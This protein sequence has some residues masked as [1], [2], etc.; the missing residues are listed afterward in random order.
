MKLRLLVIPGLLLVAIALLLLAPQ[1]ANT[2]NSAYPN[3]VK[4][5]VLAHALDVE[6][7][8]VKPA[9]WER[10]ISSGAMYAL[11]QATGEI[12]R[13]ASAVKNASAPKLPSAL[14][15]QGCQNV[16]SSLNA[17]DNIRVNQ[18]CSLRRQAEEV[19]VVNPTN[20]KNLIAGQNDSRIGYNH[21]G[22]DF[23]FDSG[24]TWGDQIPPF[25]GV[26]NPDGVVYDACS[27]PTA[28]FDS[29]G[30]AYIGGVLFEIFYADSGFYVQKS[31]APIGGA[32]FHSP[33]STNPFQT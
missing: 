2:A 11:L 27:D 33:D 31:N 25:Y 14:N 3:V 1:F 10:T 16:F 9:K 8:R 24:R 32:F 23:S 5:K 19:V 12:D 26:V 20:P 4:N 29:A 17:P 18:D 15:T 6:L 7:G 21:C 22:Y 30:N 28:T 13:R